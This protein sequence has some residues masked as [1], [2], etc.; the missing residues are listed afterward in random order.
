MILTARVLGLELGLARILGAVG[1]SVVIGLLM[2]LLFRKDEAARVASGPDPFAAG[3][4][5]AT[6][7]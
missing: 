3:A 7:R 1:F 2:A 4:A 6:H 5:A